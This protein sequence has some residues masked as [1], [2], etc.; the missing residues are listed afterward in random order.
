MPALVPTWSATV[1]FNGSTLRS[2]IQFTKVGS[3]SSIQ[4]L[5]GN[6]SSLKF[7]TNSGTI[8]DIP[9]M[10][11]GPKGDQGLQGVAG[12]QG[13]QG[14]KGDQGLQGIPGVQ[15]PKG[16]PGEGLNNFSLDIATIY[17]LSKR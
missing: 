3:N 7:G 15:G 8:V 4:L 5:S 12:P 13:P 1:T 14:P 16:D 11:I 9:R 2:T 17:M 10:F 6:S